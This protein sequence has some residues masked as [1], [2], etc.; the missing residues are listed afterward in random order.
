VKTGRMKITNPERVIPPE[1]SEE[2]R[3]DICGEDSTDR[4]PCRVCKKDLCARH[5]RY[6]AGDI[7]NGTF[8]K[9]LV[10]SGVR[11]L[12]CLVDTLRKTQ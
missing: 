10:E 3:C 6:L 8:D 1:E 12:D 9:K 11:C 2:T 7:F 4:S 5:Q